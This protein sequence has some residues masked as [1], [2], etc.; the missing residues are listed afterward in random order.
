[1]N[2]IHTQIALAS[3]GLFVAI[4]RAG[5]PVLTAD[6]ANL[7]GGERVGYVDVEFNVSGIPSIDAMHSSNNF[8]THIYIGPG[9]IVTGLGWD[10]TLLTIAAGS[11]F[12]H[13]GMS[14]THTG[15][16]I[17]AGFSF[18]PGFADDSSGG[19]ASFSSEGLIYKL[20]DS[21]INDLYAGPDGLIRLE[22]FET[23]DDG[24]NLTDGLWNIGTISFQTFYHVPA[25]GGALLIPFVA[26]LTMR[27]R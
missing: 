27:R 12:S 17:D 23:V 10:V 16:G 8:V 4:V 9:N 25:P 26:I 24:M 2:W 13:F 19:P 1:M 15:G 11:R 22:F 14:V 6:V 20:G 3:L 21:G 7:A 18:I 5:Q